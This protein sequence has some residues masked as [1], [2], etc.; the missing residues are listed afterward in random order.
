MASFKQRTGYLLSRVRA[1]FRAKIDASLSDKGLTAPQYTALT[2]L[3][4]EPGLS[5]ADMARLCLVTPQTM[6]R[7]IENLERAG[8]VGRTPHPTHGRVRQ[9]ELT[10]RGRK[11]VADCHHRV[12]ALE[13]RLVATLTRNERKQLHELLE[14]CASSLA[15]G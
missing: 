4:E 2:T 10:A 13:D 9:I 11:T 6:V 15:E 1:S 14:K 3:E 5:N 12:L 7:I 8:L